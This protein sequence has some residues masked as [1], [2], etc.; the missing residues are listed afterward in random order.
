M[1]EIQPNGYQQTYLQ[2]FNVCN[3]QWLDVLIFYHTG[4]SLHINFKMQNLSCILQKYKGHNIGLE[5]RRGLKGRCKL[6]IMKKVRISSSKFRTRLIN[7][8]QLPFFYLVAETNFRILVSITL[9]KKMNST[10]I[11]TRFEKRPEQSLKYSASGHT[12]NE[13]HSLNNEL[14]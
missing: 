13:R 4:Y 9:N 2:W 5:T 8:E 6:T 14:K 1:K 11:C 7:S 12:N 3:W 10:P